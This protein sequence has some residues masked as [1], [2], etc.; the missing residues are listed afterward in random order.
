MERKAA[1]HLSLQVRFNLGRILQLSSPLIMWP[2]IN[3]GHIT[4]VPY[5]VFFSIFI[6]SGLYIGSLKC[7]NCGYQVGRDGPTSWRKWRIWSFTKCRQC[8]HEI[9]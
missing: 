8:S 5:A 9:G 7:P 4:L 3:P 2:L 6:A 1:K